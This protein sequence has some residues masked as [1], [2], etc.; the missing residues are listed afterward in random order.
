MSHTIYHTI[1]Q[2]N[3]AYVRLSVPE[4]SCTTVWHLSTGL[5]L[6]VQK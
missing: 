6:A 5:G 1:F 3:I 2:S 4:Q